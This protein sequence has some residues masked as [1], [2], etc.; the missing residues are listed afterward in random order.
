MPLPDALMYVARR[1]KS[2][3]CPITRI[4]TKMLSEGGVAPQDRWIRVTP[5]W[6]IT[7]R[8]YYEILG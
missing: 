4:L 2:V 1:S 8:V 6:R 3:Y 5:H 7:R